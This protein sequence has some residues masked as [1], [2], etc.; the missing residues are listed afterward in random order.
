MDLSALFPS[1]A[2]VLVSLVGWIFTGAKPEPV[3]PSGYPLRVM[4]Y[5][6]HSA[7]NSAGSQDLEAIARVIEE[8]G[9]DI[10]GFQEVS[11]GRLMDGGADMPTWLSRRLGMEMLFQGTEEPHWGNAL[12]SRY[13]ILESGEGV[14]PRAGT[15]IG[16]GYLWARIDVGASEPLLVIVTHLHHLE[17]EGEVREVQVPVIL[18]FWGSRSSTVLIGDLNDW[19]GE[20]E[21]EIIEAAGLMDS[22][23]E[24]GSGPGYTWPAADPY[25][26]ID[27]IWHS[28]D[29]QAVEMQAIET[30]ASDH[31][32][33]LATIELA[34]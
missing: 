4:N 6:I 29:L 5:N 26:R 9:A 24:A 28:S 1:G 8:S 33:V 2:L 15:L 32:P 19:P 30:R 20:N 27:W 34:P 13:P 21:I 17:D 25:Q 3:Q 23:S 22:W 11:R 7:Y 14:L 10:I 31:L 18:D 12:L 16:R